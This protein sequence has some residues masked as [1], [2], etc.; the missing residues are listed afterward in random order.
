[1][2]FFAGLDLVP[3]GVVPVMCWNG[4]SAPL[5]RWPRTATFLG[6]VARKS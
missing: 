3:P 1:V 6:G 2:S 4:D 5:D